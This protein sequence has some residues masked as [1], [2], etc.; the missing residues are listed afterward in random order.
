MLELLKQAPFI[1]WESIKDFLERTTKALSPGF[2]SELSQTNEG[3]QLLSAVPLDKP[4][5]RANKTIDI[6]HHWSF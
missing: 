5:V 3:V 1:T 2:A 6:L 4:R